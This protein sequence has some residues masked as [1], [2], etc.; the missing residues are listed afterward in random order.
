MIQLQR[1]GLKILK[2]A[3]LFCASCWLGG[4]IAMLALNLKSAS[5]THAGMLYGIN[6]ASHIIDLWV[7]VTAGVYGCILTGTIYGLCTPFKF[8]K[9]SWVTAKWIITGL[10]FLSGWLLLGRWEGEMLAISDA[11]GNT[12]LQN[13]DYLQI[14]TWH[15]LF[16][17][18]QISLLLTLV[19][20][21]VFRP[22]KK[23][24]PI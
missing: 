21:S 13:R 1:K 11:L 5:A 6:Y 16:T 7:V 20:I 10:C 23:G 2:I 4:A 22:G 17:I 15:L 9:F 8:F 14:K 18:L 3:H 19:A 24:R 12:A